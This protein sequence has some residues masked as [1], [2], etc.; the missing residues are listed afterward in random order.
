MLITWKAIVNAWNFLHLL[1]CKEWKVLNFEAL[2]CLLEYMK[3]QIT[4]Q[5]SIDKSCIAKFYLWDRQEAVKLCSSY[6]PYRFWLTYGRTLEWILRVMSMLR[7][8]F[9]YLLDY[10]ASAK[11]S[12]C[13]DPEKKNQKKNHWCTRQLQRSTFLTTFCHVLTLFLIA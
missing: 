3:R 12:K 11:I 1:L 7:P 4:L 9:F 6:L 10:I 5:L 8:G 13:G 2:F